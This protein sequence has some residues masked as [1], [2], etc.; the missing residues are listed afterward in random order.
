MSG[1]C[2]PISSPGRSPEKNATV[3]IA[4]THV[5]FLLSHDKRYFG[6]RHPARG[7]RGLFLDVGAYNRISA[8]GSPASRPPTT[9]APSK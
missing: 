8:A 3:K 5:P 4:P 2:R 6:F 7:K 9:F 1:H